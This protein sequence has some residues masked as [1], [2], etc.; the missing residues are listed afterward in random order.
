M[1][2][3]CRDCLETFAEPERPGS[4][5]PG[6]CPACG[7]LRM[8]W[9]PDLHRL[10]LA[11][12]D[13]DAFYA[14]VE[15]R[16]RPELR[17]KPVIVGGG[18]R[19][20][21]SAACYVA[22]VYGV[23]SAM[24]MFKALKAC[25]DAV[26]IRPNMTKYVEVGR[27][28]RERML[29]LTPL[30]EPLSIDEAFLDLSGTEALHHGWPA[31][32]LARLVKDIEEQMGL[33]ASVG[34]SYNKFFAKVASDLDKPRGFA[35]LGFDAPKSFLAERPVGIIWGVGKS[36]RASLARD[37]ITLVRHLMPYQE[38]ELVARYGRIGQRLYHFARGE[39]DRGVS[40]QSP[41]KSISSETTFDRDIATAKQLLERLWPLCE[42]VARRLK[43]AKLAGTSVQLKLKTVDFRL[44]SRS[45]RLSDATQMAEEL[46][47]TVAPLVEQEADGRAFRLIGVGA[48]DLLAADQADLPDLLDPE[49]ARRAR[50]ERAIDQVRAKL[51]DK[52]IA[53]GRALKIIRE[54]TGKSPEHPPKRR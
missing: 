10:S 1:P 40:P 13:C 15:K 42:T 47:R 17:D 3:L 2:G 16:D 29:A 50:V 25:P 49:R 9:H 22:R 32:S 21:V 43:H 51:G 44:I 24:P 31:R 4:E 7:S 30:V 39:D 37:G 23:H 18:Q 45:R 34:L 8:V 6:R 35:V 12:I 27:A 41:A 38:K 33:T 5:R 52:A 28:I 46:Y 36:L 19:G 14:S 53:K 54:R 11:H 20:V 48:A 26:V